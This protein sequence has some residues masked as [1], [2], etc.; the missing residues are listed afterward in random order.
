MCM[1]IPCVCKGTLMKSII[2]ETEIMVICLTEEI[3]RGAT[4][5]AISWHKTC[6]RYSWRYSHPVR[7]F[8]DLV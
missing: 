8:R 6:P 4:F 1:C 2:T 5:W 7:E 3:R